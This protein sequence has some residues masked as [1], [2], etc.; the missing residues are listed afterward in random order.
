MN[1]R[2]ELLSAADFAK[3]QNL[4]L[5][6]RQIVEGLYTGGHRSRVKGGSAEFAEHRAYSAGDEI[7]LLDW[8]AYGKT[9]R[10]YVKQFEVET[11]LQ[12]VMVVDASGSM[13][14]GLSTQSKFEISR[15]ACLCL[16]RIVLQQGDA[17]GVSI[18]G[19]TIRSFVPPRSQP[20][21]LEFLTKHLGE[22]VPSGSTALSKVLSELAE[23]IKRRGII[24]IFSDCFDDVDDLLRSLKLL[25]ARR[26]EVILFH[27]L[28]PEE[29]DFSFQEWTRF[30]SLEPE[31]QVCELDTL[32][33]RE[34]YLKKFQKFLS[35]TRRACEEAACDYVP[36]RT[37]HSLAEILANYLRRRSALQK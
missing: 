28:A 33:I 19:G 23:R 26:H 20:R 16:S 15:I 27:V 30:E 34:E 21:H 14:F 31:G 36:L 17:A 25:R 8:R 11:S 32:S 35:S 22:A 10:Y 13:G 5:V 4:E 7:R 18:I 6:S 24:V 9:D 29:I 12:A 1:L 2:S 37:D 3:V